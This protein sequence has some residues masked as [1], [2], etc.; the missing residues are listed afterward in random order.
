MPLR[1]GN[2]TQRHLG[3]PVASRARP[4]GAGSEVGDTRG[5]TDL[6]VGGLFP[7]AVGS[8]RRRPGAAPRRGRADRDVRVPRAGDHRRPASA[9]W[10]A[11]SVNQRTHEFGD[12]H[13]ARRGA[14]RRARARH[15]RRTGRSSPPD[16]ASASPARSSTGPRCR[17]L[18]SGFRRPA[19][20]LLG[21]DGADRAV[22][23]RGRGR[24]A[25]RRRD[26]GVSHPGAPPRRVGRPHGRA[27]GAVVW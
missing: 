25:G 16:S 22:T 20:T 3:D 5:H 21:D 10:C 6:A 15:P 27:K 9:G 26:P 13:G 8:A 1:Q 14:Q 19:S 17:H 12:P 18:R 4:A 24:H 11:F 7:H 2:L 23:V